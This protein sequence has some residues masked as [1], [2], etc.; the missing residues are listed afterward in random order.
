M[1]CGICIETMKT[2]SFVSP[3]NKDDADDLIDLKDK[4][5]IRLRCGHAF[6]A[7]C[8]LCALRSGAG[9]PTCREGPSRYNYDEEFY[10]EEDSALVQRLDAE[11]SLIRSRSQRVRKARHT[12][13]RHGKEYRILC[14]KLRWERN[15]CI[16]KALVNF[17]LKNRALYVESAEEVR[18]SLANVKNIEFKELASKA[19]SEELEEYSNS[20]DDYVAKEYMR[21]NDVTA[22]DPISRKFWRG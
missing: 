9:C 7:S 19:T 11:I 8:I 6:H 12:L 15:A 13:N 5:C 18:N 10:L 2:E 4:E 1:D 17:R 20:I 16:K 22:M 21:C 3:T 14:D